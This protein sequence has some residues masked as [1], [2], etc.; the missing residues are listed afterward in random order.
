ML[1]NLLVFA[2]FTLCGTTAL[3]GPYF[4]EV[5]GGYNTYDMSTVNEY[6]DS[7]NEEFGTNAFEHLDS[8]G[9]FG[10]ALGW[11]QT[12]R[13]ATSVG[14]ERLSATVESSSPDVVMK[15]KAPANVISFQLAY[16]LARLGPVIPFVRGGAGFLWNNGYLEYRNEFGNDIR[17]DFNG[18]TITFEGLV[19]AE[20]RLND[21]F[22]LNL[23]GGYRFGNI[24]AAKWDATNFGGYGTFDG[25][26]FD[27]TGV[28]VRVGLRI[29]LNWE[30]GG[31][32]DAT[33][34]AVDTI[35]WM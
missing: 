19:G 28:V 4:V 3:A 21:R 27:Y 25:P 11:I 6:L 16:A 31:S 1:R 14:Y 33:N 13:L 12:R 9:S 26:G 2:A 32:A 10:V 24:S 22:G 8:G 34:E 18:S 20:V 35:G 29:G 15:I 5:T 7:V 23:A 17:H 30:F